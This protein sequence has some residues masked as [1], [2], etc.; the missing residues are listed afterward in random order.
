ME[1]RKSQRVGSVQA[2]SV[3]VI[4]Y[5]G[6][7]YP[8]TPEILSRAFLELNARAAE[9]PGSAFAQPIEEIGE[10]ESVILFLGLGVGLTFKTTTALARDLFADNYEDIEPG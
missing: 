6:V 9:L 5:D 7:D 1:G 10:G 2:V 4:R 8:V 3:H